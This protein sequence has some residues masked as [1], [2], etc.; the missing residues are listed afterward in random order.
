MFGRRRDDRDGEIAAYVR[1][2]RRRH[3]GVGAADVARLAR[4]GGRDY[5]ERDV[6]RVMSAMSR[7]LL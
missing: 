6:S 3:Q 1:G 5:S 2:L 4:Q 7:R